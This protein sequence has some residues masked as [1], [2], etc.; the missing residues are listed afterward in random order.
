MT[1]KE[2]EMFIICGVPEQM[3]PSSVLD[4]VIRG[5]QEYHRRRS[6]NFINS[7]LGLASQI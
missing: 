4:K 1:V 2:N 5:K 3:Y 6:L 7:S